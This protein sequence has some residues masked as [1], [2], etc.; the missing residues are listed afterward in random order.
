MGL[1]AFGGGK[2]QGVD[3]GQGGASVLLGQGDLRVSQGAVSGHP[4][5]HEPAVSAARLCQPDAKPEAAFGRIGLP[6]RWEKP[7]N[8]A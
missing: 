8:Q 5:E 1:V 7:P 2:G 4:E 6:G 3:P